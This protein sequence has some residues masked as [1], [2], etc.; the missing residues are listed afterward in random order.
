[1]TSLR[2]ID[3]EMHIATLNEDAHLQMT[4][5][6]DKGRGYVSAEKEQ[7]TP[8]MPIRVIPVGSIF[9]PI[10]K[11]NYTVTD[12]AWARSPTMTS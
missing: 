11:V 4:L 5:T 7:S 6:I 12:T 2:F 9:T 8:N 10:R 3:P 1:M